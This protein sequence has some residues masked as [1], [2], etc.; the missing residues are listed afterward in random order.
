MADIRPGRAGGPRW[1]SAHA[2]PAAARGRGQLSAGE[3]QG[4]WE[5]LGPVVGLHRGRRAEPPGRAAK[6]GR[7]LPSPRGQSRVSGEQREDTGPP[8][9][10]GASTRPVPVRRYGTRLPPLENSLGQRWVQTGPEPRG[11]GPGRL[12][13][14]PRRRLKLATRR[15]GSPRFVGLGSASPLRRS[16]SKLLRR[17]SAEGNRVLPGT[18]GQRLRRGP[19]TLGRGSQETGTATDK[20]RRQGPGS[21]PSAGGDVSRGTGLRGRPAVSGLCQGQLLQPL[22]S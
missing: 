18:A 20:R 1:V 22:L 21:L 5:P 4:A 6:A 7:Q 19:A 17:P 11:S 13:H 12:V 14:V 2:G 15:P 10:P 9:G 8:A 3:G 16:A